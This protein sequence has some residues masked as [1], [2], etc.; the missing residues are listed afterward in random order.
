MHTLAAISWGLA[1]A[2][3]LGVVHLCVISTIAGP[4]REGDDD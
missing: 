1:F 3:L 2:M 4:P